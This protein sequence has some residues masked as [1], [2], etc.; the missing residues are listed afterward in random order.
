LQPA[1]AARETPTIASTTPTTTA[2][3]TPRV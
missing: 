1:W 3:R 2:I